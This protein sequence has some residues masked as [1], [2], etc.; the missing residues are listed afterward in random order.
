MEEVEQFEEAGVVE[1]QNSEVPEAGCH[2]LEEMQ[3]EIES[4]LQ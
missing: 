3:T 1:A 2:L 4:R